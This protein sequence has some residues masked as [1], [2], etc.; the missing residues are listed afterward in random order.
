MRLSFLIL[1]ISLT[2]SSITYGQLRE[3][4]LDTMREQLKFLASDS[5]K[6]RFPGTP[7]DAVSADFIREKFSEAGFQ[8]LSNNGSQYFSIVTSV[9]AT[10]DN[11]LMWN[12]AVAAFEEDFSLYAFSSNASAAT[13]VV[14]VGYGMVIDLDSLQRNDYLNKDVKGKWVL[15][16]EGDPEPENNDSPYIPFANARSKALNA[17]D[18]GAAGLLV[19]GGSQNDPKDELTPLLF[20]RSVVSSGIPVIDLKRAWVDAN[21]LPNGWT[22]DSLETLANKGIESLGELESGK[23][24]ATTEL[25]RQEVETQNVIAYLPGSDPVL[26]KEFVILGAHYDHLGMGGQGSGSR[27]PDTIAPHYGADDNGSG[28]VGMIALAQRFGA[29][30]EKPA[31]SLVVTAFGAEELGLIGSRYFAQNIPFEAEHLNAM[32]NFDMIGRLNEQKSIAIGGTGTSVES[33]DLLNEL[34]QNTELGF[35]YS[36]EG[37]GPSDHASFYAIDVPVFFVS[38]GAHDDYHTP[39]DTWDKIDYEGMQLVVDFGEDLLLELLNRP[40]RLN[41]QEAGP[42]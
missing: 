10:A 8:L 29:M 27:T 34:K 21:M 36:A 9:E 28:V 11:Q 16:L 13:E 7:E 15:V 12:N 33:E 5:L 31:R 41:F 19:V 18:Q 22:T 30:E 3:S 6:G 42:K 20:E 26:N 24:A 23:L 40:E 35:S 2:V 32:V 4:E 14:F 17:R 37:F 1:F 39:A 38:T 25:E